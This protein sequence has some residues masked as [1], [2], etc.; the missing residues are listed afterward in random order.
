MGK[1]Q[2][3]EF[4]DLPE[5]VQKRL[6]QWHIIIPMP[7]GRPQP[8][9]GPAEPSTDSGDTEPTPDTPDNDDP[10]RSDES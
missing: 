10:A 2:K 7:G 4:S 9:S 3:L 5:D 8:P 1:I 6:Q